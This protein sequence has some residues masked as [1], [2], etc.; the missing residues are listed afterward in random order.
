MSVPAPHWLRRRWANLRRGWLI[1]RAVRILNSTLPWIPPLTWRQWLVLLV[2]S[3][4]LFLTLFGGVG[5][6]A[7]PPSGL[8]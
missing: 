6:F 8:R 5:L 7:V 4:V 1:R 3:V 2:V